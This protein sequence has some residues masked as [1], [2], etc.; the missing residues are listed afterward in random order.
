MQMNNAL[1]LIHNKQVNLI[2]VQDVL[3]NKYV[4][5]DKQIKKI[6]FWIL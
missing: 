2:L 6:L 4:R 5:V 3:I 1:E